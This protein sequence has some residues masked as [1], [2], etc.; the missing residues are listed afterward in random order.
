[1]LD[2]LGIRPDLIVGS[3][4]GAI[5][6]A[7]YA[8]G[9][10]G[11]EIDSIVRVLP[12]ASVIRSYSPGAP[13]VIGALPAFAV[14]EK[15]GRGFALQTG[16]VRESEVNALMSALLLRGNLLARGDFDHLPIPWRGIGTRLSTRKAVVFSTGS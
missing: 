6:G 2:S 4:I 12:I 10:S 1:M 14:W 16:A 13:G 7:L 5:T 8:S 3:S 9:Y 11:H 15:Y